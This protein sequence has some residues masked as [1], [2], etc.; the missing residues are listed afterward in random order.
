MQIIAS[1]LRLILYLGLM[2]TAG[3]ELILVS[4]AT[5]VFSYLAGKRASEQGQKPLEEMDEPIGR[6]QYAADSAGNRQYA[7]DIRI[8]NLQ[9]WMRSIWDGGMEQLKELNR[10]RSRILLRGDMAGAG[11]NLLRRSSFYI[12]GRQTASAQ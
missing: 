12:S 8:F 6:M 9:G 3:P 10:K 2:V 5:A 1:I 7:K 11:M 4:A